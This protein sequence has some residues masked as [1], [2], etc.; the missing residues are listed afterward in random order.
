VFTCSVLWLSCLSLS[1]M[2]GGRCLL[3]NTLHTILF[4]SVYV[5]VCVICICECM[6]MSDMYD[7]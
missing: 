2:V 4:I 5:C 1:D 7:M 3:F 6:C